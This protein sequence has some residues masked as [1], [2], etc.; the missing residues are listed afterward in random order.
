MFDV[1]S[2][3]VFLL[4]AFGKRFEQRTIGSSTRMRS[5]AKRREWHQARAQRCTWE[6][7][8]GILKV[9][10]ASLHGFMSCSPRIVAA[11]PADVFQGI[12][13][14]KDLPTP[15]HSAPQPRE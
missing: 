14:A 11:L 3:L 6:I 7:V 1:K 12:N 5:E 10:Q 15:L 2:R 9:R 4:R 13:K 8:D